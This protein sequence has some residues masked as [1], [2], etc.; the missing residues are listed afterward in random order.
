MGPRKKK[1]L[2]ELQWFISGV[3][4]GAII[5]FILFDMWNVDITFSVMGAGVLV[6]L[7]AMYVVRLTIW[8]FN[9]APYR[10][11]Q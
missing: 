2:S 5:F 8:V 1:I 6:T 3:V 11:R 7:I 9:K 4:A 10:A